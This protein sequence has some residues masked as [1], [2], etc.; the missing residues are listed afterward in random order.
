[1]SPNRTAHVVIELVV[2]KPTE[3]LLPARF[4]GD[5]V[6]ADQPG[7][8]CALPEIWKWLDRVVSLSPT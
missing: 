5:R 1:M 7:L 4:N 3:A 2:A 8:I 6:T